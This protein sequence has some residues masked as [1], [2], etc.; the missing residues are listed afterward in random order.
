MEV[1]PTHFHENR[2]RRNLGYSSIRQ[3]WDRGMKRKMEILSKRKSNGYIHLHG[4]KYSDAEGNLIPRSCL[5]D[6]ITNSALRI[7]KH[8]NKIELYNQCPTIIVK[9]KHISEI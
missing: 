1:K 8:I 3:M 6:A 4:S 2:D 7:G 5:Q 9:D